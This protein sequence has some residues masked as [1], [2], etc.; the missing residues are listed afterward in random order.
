M[1]ILRKYRKF[2]EFQQI[3]QISLCYFLIPTCKWQYKNLVLTLK[4][5]KWA[6]ARW[7]AMA[8]VFEHSL[9]VGNAFTTLRF[10]NVRWTSRGFKSGSGIISFKSFGKKKLVKYGSNAQ[11]KANLENQTC[12]NSGRF[13]SKFSITWISWFDEQA[14]KELD[15]VSTV[16]S[17]TRS[18]FGFF[19]LTFKKNTVKNE[20]NWTISKKYRKNF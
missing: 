4:T 10:K 16:D 5:V 15:T 18:S 19:G 1:G 6:D 11:K 8:S 20:I 9:L 14:F 2:Y 3:E 17:E 12:S 7:Y 13:L